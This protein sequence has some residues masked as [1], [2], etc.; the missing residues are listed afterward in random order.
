MQKN[1][2]VNHFSL[3]AT[4]LLVAI[5]IIVSNFVI[6]IPLFGFP[7][8]RFSVT[9]I[10]IF[11]VGSLFGGVYGVIAGFISDMI[12]FM[13]T[14]QGAPYHP[15]FT[16]NAMLVGLIPGI[17]FHHIKMRRNKKSFNKMNLLLGVIAL[18]GSIVYINFIGIHEVENIG[19]IMGIPIN[20]IL[21]ILMIIIL[22]A[23]VGIVWYVQKKFSEVDSAYSI[24]KIIF[25]NIISFV[26]VQLILTPIWLNNLY[27]I[28][29]MASAFVRV[30]KSLIDIPLQAMLSYTILRAIPV[31]IK[32]NYLCK[33]N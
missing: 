8:V 4:A 6:Y 17:I 29:I 31:K 9:S 18:V 27:N 25:I 19:P 5:S 21:S 1:N 2:Q 16:I 10:P 28:P 11:L 26:V 30:F 33:N 14:S 7:S 3:T 13:I 32:G 22:A 12:S 23:L 15:G 24:D 20:I